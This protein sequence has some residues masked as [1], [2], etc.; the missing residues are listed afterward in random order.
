MSDLS[1][2]FYPH[3]RRSYTL[4]R[5]YSRRTN[6]LLWIALAIVLVL[7]FAV[8][9]FHL[10]DERIGAETA[11]AAEVGEIRQNDYYCN[12]IAKGAMRIDPKEVSAN[13]LL[14]L[15]AQYLQPSN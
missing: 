13:E 7:G 3:E 8:D 11:N 4:R 2:M 6:W 10:T 12:Q 15:C 9:N 1:E 5:G 14:A